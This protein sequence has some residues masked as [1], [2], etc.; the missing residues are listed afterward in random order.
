MSH[1]TNATNYTSVR[2][3]YAQTSDATPHPGPGGVS[4]PGRFDDRAVIVGSPPADS[5]MP[6]PLSL[7]VGVTAAASEPGIPHARKVE[8]PRAQSDAATFG[9][10][11]A[12]FRLAEESAFQL[13]AKYRDQV[14]AKYR[15]DHAAAPISGGPS[16]PHGWENGP[17][18][19]RILGQFEAL[20]R[21]APDT[22]AAALVNKSTRLL[23]R[24]MNGRGHLDATRIGEQISAVET[25]MAE[26]QSARNI[27][28]D[29]G[30]RNL[31][32]AHAAPTMDEP[33]RAMSSQIL[34]DY[35]NAASYLRNLLEKPDGDGSEIKAFAAEIWRAACA[36]APVPAGT[37]R[38]IPIPLKPDQERQIAQSS[39]SLIKEDA[40]F[41]A[42]FAVGRMRNVE[43]DAED[44]LLS[45]AEAVV[46]R[47]RSLLPAGTL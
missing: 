2:T 25:K 1:H 35:T 47:A 20:Q 40:E 8:R 36:A 43:V 15:E 46:G 5:F 4:S 34:I 18:F 23:D 9:V 26:L 27:R 6:S 41:I 30:F 10:A 17:K 3:G 21:S 11:R 32:P 37:S 7:A 44:M 45:V 19:A 24:I 22:A 33:T 12:A 42:S 29:A 31:F 14:I 16:A 38:P 28:Q 39:L 13:I